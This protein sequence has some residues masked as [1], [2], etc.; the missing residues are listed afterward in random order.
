MGQKNTR[1]K[2]LSR[3]PGRVTREP[4]RA[5]A[6]W[7]TSVVKLWDY[8]LVIQ[9]KY[10]PCEHIDKISIIKF[11]QQQLEGRTSRHSASFP[12]QEV[13]RV[14]KFRFILF[15]QSPTH[16][17]ALDRYP[18]KADRYP[19]KA[20]RKPTKADRYP[21][22]ADRS[23]TRP[24]QPELDR[25]SPSTPRNHLQVTRRRRVAAIS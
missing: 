4:P 23:R 9:N 25:N 5:H 1:I 17:R 11:A 10:K 13:S 7:R 12:I 6:Q 8:K 3:N 21:T 18:T 22:K 24:T 20:D 2:V 14:T 15:I 19:T 16:P